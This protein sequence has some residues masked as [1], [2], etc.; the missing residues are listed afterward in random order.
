MKYTVYIF[1]RKIGI[2]RGKSYQN[3]EKVYKW[4][5]QIK[6]YTE[7]WLRFKIQFLFAYIH[8]LMINKDLV[9]IKTS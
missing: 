6:E 1:N 3:N 2:K 4:K 5:T 7:T 9:S 8:T